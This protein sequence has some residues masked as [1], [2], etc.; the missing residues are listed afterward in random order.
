MKTHYQFIH[1]EQKA[2]TKTTYC[3]SCKNNKN[4]AQLGEV[5]WYPQWRQW[6]YFPTIEAVYSADCLKD[7]QDF[8]G[9]LKGDK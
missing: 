7:I 2:E 9:Q 8:I 5:R 4:G 6:C 1:F 3:W